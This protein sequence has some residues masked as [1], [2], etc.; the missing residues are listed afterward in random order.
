MITRLLLLLLLA[1]GVGYAAPIVADVRADPDPLNVTAVLLASA[2]D[3][4]S[5]A[6]VS[7]PHATATPAPVAVPEVDPV[8]DP[9]GA[10]G[11]LR[12]FW[13]VNHALAILLGVLLALRA[14][15]K[16]VPWLRVG[17]RLTAVG[18]VGT[19]LATLIDTW[20]TTPGQLVRWVLVA[21]LGTALTLFR[22]EQPKKP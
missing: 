8:D 7:T 20:P 11:A 10:Y 15:S 3:A 21:V 2:P 18:G 22:A 16:R 14:A 4:G 17:W 13:R 5:V 6:P 1:F 12:D 19:L 9:A